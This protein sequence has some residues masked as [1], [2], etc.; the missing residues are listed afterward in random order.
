MELFDYQQ[1][2]L[3]NEASYH[4]KPWQILQQSVTC[5]R[6]VYV[7][8]MGDHGELFRIK[9][10]FSVVYHQFTTTRLHRLRDLI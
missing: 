10:C 8:W 3:T 9:Q 7:N 5:N 1:F 4:D 2:Q 6:I